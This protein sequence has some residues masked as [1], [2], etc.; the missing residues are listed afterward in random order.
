MRGHL[1]S[2]ELN[3]KKRPLPLFDITTHRTTLYTTLW[4]LW[5]LFS[6]SHKYHTFVV[7]IHFHIKFWVIKICQRS[8]FW[9]IKHA[10]KYSTLVPHRYPMWGTWGTYMFFTPFWGTSLFYHI[11]HAWKYCRHRSH[12]STSPVPH[13]RYLRYIHVICLI[14]RYIFQLTIENAVLQNNFAMVIVVDKI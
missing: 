2:V 10:W 8:L 5:Y 3:H 13:V 9:Q 4:Y 11:K 14:L 7:P 12:F 1:R 6:I